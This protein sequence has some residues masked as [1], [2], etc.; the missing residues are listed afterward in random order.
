[1]AM[2]YAVLLRLPGR[3]VLGEACCFVVDRTAVINVPSP[4]PGFSASPSIRGCLR[5]DVPPPLWEAVMMCRNGRG[6]V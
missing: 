5:V 6:F 2:P 1:M 3:A 4:D